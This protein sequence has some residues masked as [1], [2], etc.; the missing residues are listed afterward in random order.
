MTTLSIILARALLLGIV[1]MAAYVPDSATSGDTVRI[2]V[3]YDNTTADPRLSAA[4]GF[5]AL[6]EHGDH[7]LLLDAG[8]DPRI[9]LDNADS[10]GID[11]RRIEAIA[12]SHAHGDHTNGLQALVERGVRVPVYAL[13]SFAPGLRDRFGDAVTVV[14]TSPGDELLP[15]VFTTGE[16]MDPQVGIPEQAFVIPTAS[17]LVVLTGCAHPG[18][19]A[20]AQRAV[21]LFGLRVYLVLGGFHLAAKSAPEVQGIIAEFR[22]LGVR[23]VGPMHCTGE[24][25]IAAFAAAYGADFVK[26]GAGRV[27]VVGR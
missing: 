12:I 14:E 4:W 26:G 27:I 11:L 2:T 9:L 13:P 8:G 10:L 21:A 19:V 24:Q 17:G 22:R 25:A 15:G 18:I 23:S 7:T 16:M 1:P 3:L 20:I 6:I 5:A